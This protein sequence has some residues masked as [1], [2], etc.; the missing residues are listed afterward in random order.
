M[1]QY[2]PDH[3][4]FSSI[5]IF[6][7]M[8]YQDQFHRAKE[9]SRS[10]AALTTDKKNTLLCAIADALQANTAA[11]ISENQKDL[12]AFPNGTMADRLLLSEERIQ[13]MASDVRSVAQLPDEVGAL[14]ESRK[15]PNGLKI[16]QVRVPLGVVGMIYESRPN[17]TVDAAA[18]AIKSGNAIVLKGGK[19]AACSNRILSVVMRDALFSVGADKEM[20]QL[21][22]TTD[23]EATT[24]MLKAR[25]LIDVVIPRGGKGLIRFVS[26]NALVPV[27]ETGASVV[28]TF[29]DSSAEIQ[30]TL[31]IVINEKL[32][33][34]SVCNAL[35]T[36]LV[37]KD[38]APAFLPLF[39]ERLLCETQKNGVPLVRMHVDETALSLM[40]N[41][42]SDLILRAKEGD[43]ST[44][45]LDYEMSIKVV[46]NINEAIE[47]IQAYSLG[48]SESICSQDNVNIDRFLREVDAACVYAN[49][50]TCFSDGAQ[51]GLGAEIG[52]STQKLHV[53]GPFALQGLTSVKWVIRG[54]GQTRP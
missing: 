29:V 1:I 38:I 54:N 14:L 9:A 41:V 5:L 44:E 13:A 46:S 42:S 4:P 24:Q 10:L 49:A 21:L 19:E 6:E 39:A 2:A 30:K 47:H 33:R 15:M 52:I 23:R 34:V 12:L 43:Y 40:A 45:W 37:H 7:H 48:H 53:R 50:S 20:I 25:G 26:S 36:L 18:L 32:R 8:T 51:F 17:V 16:S 31:E 28:H 11:I 3:C 35:D 22:D 27:I